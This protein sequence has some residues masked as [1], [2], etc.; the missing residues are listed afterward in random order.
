MLVI[1]RVKY[2]VELH[3]S[4]NL[5]I[6][7]TPLCIAL[8]FVLLS[9]QPLR[10]AV[11]FYVEKTSPSS[12][13]PEQVQLTVDG[14]Q[15]RMDAA[16][17]ATGT[18]HSVIYR[19]NRND[20]DKEMMILHHAEKQVM[21]INRQSVRAMATQM[22]N[23]MQQMQGQMKNLPPEVRAKM[24][25]MMPQV[26]MQTP[27]RLNPVIKETG[28]QDRVNGY[29]CKEHEVLRDD[30]THVICA[31]AWRHMPSGREVHAVIQDMNQFVQELLVTFKQASPMMGDMMT[32]LVGMEMERGFPVRIREVQNNELVWETQLRNVDK[33]PSVDATL[34]EPPAGYRTQRM[35]LIGRESR[36]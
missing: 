10:A 5:E 14:K 21:I 31:T 28:K 29:A 8:F 30:K 16:D 22:S 35:G 12:A 20:A 34:F 2:I 4:P 17:N 25:N 1:S 27:D 23:M 11:V 13:Q 33:K 19:S 15:L 36:K 18:S 7:M 6:L 32:P 3:K 24:G 9:V 26:G